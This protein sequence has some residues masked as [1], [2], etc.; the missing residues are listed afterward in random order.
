MKTIIAL[1]ALAAAFVTAPA[2]ASPSKGPAPQVISGHTF[3][4][5]NAGAPSLG[6]GTN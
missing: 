6:P 4:E 5:W 3:E 2:F 1:A